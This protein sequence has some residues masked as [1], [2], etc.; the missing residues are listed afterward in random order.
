MT[1]ENT[2]G[3]LS[4]APTEATES[5]QAPEQP[6]EARLTQKDID[7][8][9]GREKTQAKEAASVAKERELL[10]ALG[11]ENVGEAQEALTSYRKVQE[12]NQTETDKAVKRAEKA[13]KQVTDLTGYKERAERSEAALASYATSLQEGLPDS[14]TTMLDRMDAVDQL[15]WLTEHREEYVKKEEPKPEVTRFKAPDTTRR[16]PVEENVTGR[17]RLRQ[18]FGQKYGT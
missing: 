7:K 3:N 9:V 1:E 12:E 13:E 11:V 10:E 18:V 6:T 16:A 17:E 2:Q 14:L 15:E 5:S 4:E 8:I